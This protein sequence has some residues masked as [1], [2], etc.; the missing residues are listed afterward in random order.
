MPWR[1]GAAGP[2]IGSEVLGWYRSPARGRGPP[3]RRPAEDGQGLSKVPPDSLALLLEELEGA[4]VVDRWDAVIQNNAIRNLASHLQ[5]I[6]AGCANHDRDIA[7]LPPSVNHVK[8]DP[9]NIDE[10]PMEG[11]SLHIEQAAQD[12]H[13]LTHRRQRLA[14]FD[15]DIAGQWVPPGAQSADDPDRGQVVQSE[16]CCCQKADVA[17]PVVDH[18]G[19]DF[20]P[21]VT[22]A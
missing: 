22:A 2:G 6:V 1:Y 18:S 17:C 16:K 3:N 4:I 21:L 11:N 12:E 10:F 14:A 13:S 15:T 8:L 5:H 20:Y 9:I 7:R 19:T